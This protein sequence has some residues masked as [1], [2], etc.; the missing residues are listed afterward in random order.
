MAH[1]QDEHGAFKKAN[2][3]AL[4]AR[5]DQR[6]A[7]WELSQENQANMPKRDTT[8][9]VQKIHE[10]QFFDNFEQTQLLGQKIQKLIDNFEVVPQ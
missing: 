1:I 3:A 5:R 2:A 10:F 4:Q 6:S 9:R 7:E 8:I